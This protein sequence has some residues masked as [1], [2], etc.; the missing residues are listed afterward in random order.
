M[1]M[2]TMV[3]RCD[4]GEKNQFMLAAE[5][6]ELDGSFLL[7]KLVHLFLND[8]DVRK[9]ALSFDT[10]YFEVFEGVLAILVLCISILFIVNN[11]YMPSL[12]ANF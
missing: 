5:H 10:N 4:S 7:L 6:L 11:T 9:K 2:T 3:F 8:P 1:D 12:Y